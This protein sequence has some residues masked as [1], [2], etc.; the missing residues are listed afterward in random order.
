MA[1]TMGDRGLDP[2]LEA[3]V[4]SSVVEALQGK[5]SNLPAFLAS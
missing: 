5:H 2:G 1:T 3:L 4:V